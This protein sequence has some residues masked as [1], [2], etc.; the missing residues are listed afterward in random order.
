MISGDN[1]IFARYLYEDDSFISFT[2]APRL[3]DV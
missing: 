1:P 3:D 2:I